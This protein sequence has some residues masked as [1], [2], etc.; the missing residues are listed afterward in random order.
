[1]ELDASQE[2]D[3]TVPMAGN[4]GQI[5]KPPKLQMVVEGSD[6][7]TAAAAAEGTAI[8]PVP[9]KAVKYKECLKNHAAST[10]GHILDG[11]GEF[12]PSGEE[13]TMEALKCAACS[14]HRNFHRR[15]AESDQPTC[16]SIDVA[17]DG[18]RFAQQSAQHMMMPFNPNPTDCN[19]EEVGMMHSSLV[20]PSLGGA[21]ASLIPLRGMKKRFRTK[22]SAD[23]KEKMCA[24]AEKLG[25]RI[26][27]EDEAAVQQFCSDV[28]LKRRILK[29]WMHNNKH[30]M[31]K[32]CSPTKSG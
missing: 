32:K 1:M 26:Q 18:K 8:V 28:G 5:Y 16:F 10:G 9:K 25:W 3:I 23:Q 12:M 29:V 31:G 24:F 30:T 21:Y 7:G 15:E 20:H 11:C 22:F 6:E 4:Y 19:E 13:G 2:C 14:C 17:K 27:K